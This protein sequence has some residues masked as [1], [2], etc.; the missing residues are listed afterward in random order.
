MIMDQ[1]LPPILGAFSGTTIESPGLKA[2]FSGLPENNPPMLFC[3]AITD[4]SA[5]I[6]NTAFLS[7]SCVTPPD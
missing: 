4:P 7:A 1:F 2:A 6:T 3:D 5:R